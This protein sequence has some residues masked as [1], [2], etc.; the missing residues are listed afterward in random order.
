MMAVA[1]AA[2]RS[3]EMYQG[4]IDEFNKSIGVLEVTQPLVEATM[5]NL[6]VEQMTGAILSDAA[7]FII[8]YQ[9]VTPANYLQV[10]KGKL[11]DASQTFMQAVL[12]EVGV[13]INAS[14]D[15]LDKLAPTLQSLQEVLRTLA[16]CFPMD[17]WPQDMSMEAGALMQANDAAVFDSSFVNH[18]SDLH[19]FLDR[20]PVELPND[21]TYQE[22]LACVNQSVAGLHV[23]GIEHAAT[24][25]EIIASFVSKTAAMFDDPGWRRI[26][27]LFKQ[28]LS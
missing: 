19:A 16:V 13:L 4:L 17:A 20:T 25:N 27:L 5:K 14:T 12:K 24:M 2:V 26:G 7:N 15:R 11:C 9:E 8:K 22:A 28:L 3:S 6:S 21:S 23:R 10:L 18:F 1:A